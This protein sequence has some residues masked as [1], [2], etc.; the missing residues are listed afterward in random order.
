MVGDIHEVH[1]MGPSLA[2]STSPDGK[3]QVRLV[4]INALCDVNGVVMFR[5]TGS[6][7][8]FPMDKLGTN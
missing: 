8:W 2:D 6:L 7:W 4:P 5:Q 1:R 3:R